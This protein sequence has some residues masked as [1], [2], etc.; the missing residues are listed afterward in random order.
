MQ[1]RA[2]TGRGSSFTIWEGGKVRSSEHQWL[3]KVKTGKEDPDWGRPSPQSSSVGTLHQMASHQSASKMD[4]S[5]QVPG[6]PAAAESAEI[7][8]TGGWI[9][10]SQGGGVVQ[11]SRSQFTCCS[12]G[13]VNN[14][15]EASR[16]ASS[17][18]SQPA[19]GC[20]T[21]LKSLS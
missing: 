4:V 16:A 20:F 13:L 18:F 2:P 21:W 8:E 5:T 9:N 3:R 14:H 10:R 11:R 12:T 6:F 1:S 19:V 15:P 17:G 7:K